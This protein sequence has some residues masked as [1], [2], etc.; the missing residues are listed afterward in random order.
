MCHLSV[1]V[2]SKWNHVLQQ[3]GA[4]FEEFETEI[5][6]SRLVAGKCAGGTKAANAARRF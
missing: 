2:T 4:M 1:C 6:N 5:E 3:V